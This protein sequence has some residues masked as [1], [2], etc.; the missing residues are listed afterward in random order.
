MSDPTTTYL[1]SLRVLLGTDWAWE[2]D[3][4][5]AYMTGRHAGGLWFRVSTCFASEP[6]DA[7]VG[8]LAEALLDAVED[9]VK[10]EAVITAWSAHGRLERV[11]VDA[12]GKEPR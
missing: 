12:V 9:G 2:Y 5:C 7:D 10:G 8:M 6:V 4:P 1:D 11:R 3:A